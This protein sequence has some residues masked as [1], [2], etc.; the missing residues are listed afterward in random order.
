[1][2]KENKLAARLEWKREEGDDRL[3][4]GVDGVK[5]VGTG[6]GGRGGGGEERGGG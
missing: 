3:K 5:D 2:E 6:K 4:K 1:M